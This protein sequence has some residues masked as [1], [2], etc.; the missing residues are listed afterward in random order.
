MTEL[1]II[2]AML[3]AV[4]SNGVTSTIGRHPQLMKA[5]PILSR[6]NN[7]IQGDGH[8]FNTDYKLALSKDSNSEFVVP[9]ATLKCDTSVRREPYV[10]RGRRMYDPQANTYA[11]AADELLVDVVIR[12][13]YEDLPL[14]MLEFLTS[15]SIYH[16]VL[17]SE[18]TATEIQ[19]RKDAMD[20]AELAFNRERLRQHDVTLRDNPDYITIIAGIRGGTR[21]LSS[22][23]IGGL[24]NA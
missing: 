15:K 14:S 19:A 24:P 6:F 20:T 21:N 13:D 22:N 23:Y 12:L 9:Q 8:W 11:I 17:N 10:R 3:A 4:G 16:M 7:A 18:I 5:A 2:N 1:D